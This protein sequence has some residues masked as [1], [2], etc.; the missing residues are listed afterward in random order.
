LNKQSHSGLNKL[1]SALKSDKR[2]HEIFRGGAYVLIAK[3]IVSLLGLFTNLF[4]AR[5]YGAEIIGYVATINSI[6]A[7]L[8]TLSLLGNQ[9]AILRFIPEFL[10]KYNFKTTYLLIRKLALVILLMATL[11]T[12][13]FVLNL[14]QISANLFHKPV[15]EQPLFISLLFLLVFSLMAFSQQVLRGLKLI[16][17][18]VLNLITIP[19]LNLLLLILS[20]F[21]FYHTFNAIYTRVIATLC[22]AIFNFA[23]IHRYF[24]LQV[25]LNASSIQFDTKPLLITA[26][27]ML[28]TTSLATIMG[29]VDTLMIAKYLPA[30]QVG[31]YHVALKIALLT[32]LIIQ[33]VNTLSAPNYSELFHTKQTQELRKIITKTSI[34]LFVLVSPIFLIFFFFGDAIISLTFGPIFSASNSSLLV[35]VSGFYIATLFGSN[36][37]FLSMTG[38]Q[39]T[40]LVLILI[41]FILNVLLNTLL[42]PKFGIVGAAIATSS[43]IF[44]KNLMATLFIYHRHRI[45]TSI[46]SLE[47]LRHE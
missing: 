32:T 5:Y 19:L 22:V 4:M 46:F 20:T 23:L 7:I 35:L 1:I 16:H 15:I 45:N 25:S 37:L 10:N 3:G 41:T 29:Q 39:N 31:L 38:H 42:I 14:S 36:S 6:L 27:P 47:I 26:L 28:A 21:F 43:S 18:Y 34:L 11:L 2:F 30:T 24:H 33:S 40:L 12:V 17:Q 13:I 9:T 44:I 8:I